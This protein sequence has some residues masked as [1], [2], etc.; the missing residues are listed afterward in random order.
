MR[1]D[2][3][4]NADELSVLRKLNSPS[5]I[6]DFLESLPQNKELNGDTCMSPRFVLRKKTA[7]CI[8]GALFAAA[9][10]WLHGEKPLV[11]DLRA[12]PYDFDHVI[13]LFRQH[14]YWGA[15][16]KTNHSVLRYREPIYKTVRELALS[17]F[18]EYTDERGRKTLRHYSEKPF[19]L[20]K[21]KEKKWITSE[22][23]LW[24]IQKALD[25]APHSTILTKSHRLRKADPIEMKAGELTQW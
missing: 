24:Y 6:Q 8:E 12:D 11:F 17:Y 9:A 20:T 15:I 3:G 23:G 10:L 16:S 1:T 14:G 21:L 18:H 22:K 7:H 4:F 5:K 2:L 13:A 19:D 25:S